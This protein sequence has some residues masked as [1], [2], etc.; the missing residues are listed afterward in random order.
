VKG[1]LFR[2]ATALPV[3]PPLVPSPAVANDN[4][5]PRPTVEDLA[6]L[7]IPELV[8]RV[9]HDLGRSD[10][11]P[12]KAALIAALTGTPEDEVQRRVAAAPSTP[13]VERAS[14]GIRDPLERLLED[15][16]RERTSGELDPADR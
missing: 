8:L 5:P 13:P 11:P 12:S 3:S 9:Q 15:E 6:R 14:H 4:A 16:E 7:T 2:G 1:V 10:V